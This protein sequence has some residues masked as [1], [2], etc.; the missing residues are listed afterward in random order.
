MPRRSSDVLSVEEM[1]S[2]VGVG[3]Q[4][5]Y[6]QC[7]LWLASDGRDGIPCRR[8][9]RLILVYRNELERWLGF[10]FVWPPDN[11]A[12][13]KPSALTNTAV[14]DAAS[15]RSRASR[16]VTADQTTLPF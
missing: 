4:T 15:T 13:A 6:A 1:A 16:R 14:P 10:P 5:A 2:V 8:V 7:R 9:G 11:E 12:R 3:R